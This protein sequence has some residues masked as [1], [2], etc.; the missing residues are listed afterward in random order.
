MAR[1]LRERHI[2]EE[3]TLAAPDLLLWEL[4]NVLRYKPGLSP[5]D[6]AEA[7]R[8]VMEMRVQLF[9]LS[10]SLLDRALALAY[11]TGITVYDAA[12]VALA[13]E[14]GCALATADDRLVAKV[15]APAIL[16]SQL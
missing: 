5:T 6:A 8:S 1:L 15:G 3:I 9:H 10:P 11:H 12:F 16:L 7:V 14:L 13:G 4:S 2:R